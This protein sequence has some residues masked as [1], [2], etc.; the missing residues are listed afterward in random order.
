[1]EKL[2]GDAKAF[3]HQSTYHHIVV[4]VFGQSLDLFRR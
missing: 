4:V 2:E 3:V 1:M